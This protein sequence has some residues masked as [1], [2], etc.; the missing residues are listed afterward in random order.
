MSPLKRLDL[1]AF[2]FDDL[3]A[4]PNLAGLERL[5]VRD[6][7][8]ARRSGS[9]T[10]RL[11]LPKLAKATP[12]L[13]AFV[14]D[15]NLERPPAG[16]D[17]QGLEDLKVS[18]LTLAQLLRQFEP[19][20]LR[21]TRLDAGL[22]ATTDSDP[23]RLAEAA[24]NLKWLALRR[25]EGVHVAR[26]EKAEPLAALEVL[27]LSTPDG[28]PPSAMTAAHVNALARAPFARNLKALVLGRLKNKATAAAAIKGFGPRCD[29]Y[30]YAA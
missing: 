21:L 4:W 23:V 17:W 25:L 9:T 6:R 29:A 14:T 1:D 22:W 24:P 28:S 26:L 19:L 8:R 5:T 20:L 12:N 2:L 27:D 13:R 7:H 18:G 11:W 10:D 16:G 30:W 3:P 15:Q